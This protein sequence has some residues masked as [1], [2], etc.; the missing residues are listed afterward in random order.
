MQRI[1]IPHVCEVCGVSLPIF[2][3]RFCFENCRRRWYYEKEIRKRVDES[4]KNNNTDKLDHTVGLLV[5]LGY[6]VDIR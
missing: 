6:K 1:E 2:K 5:K 4:I 3:K